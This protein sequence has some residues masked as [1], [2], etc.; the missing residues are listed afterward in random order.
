[1]TTAFEYLNRDERRIKMPVISAAIMLG[2]SIVIFS[3]LASMSYSAKKLEADYS[4]AAERMATKAQTFIDRARSMLPP[5][6]LITD[7]EQKTMQHNLAISGTYSAWT[8]F[9]NTLESALPENSV[10]TAIEN[11]LS[12]K[13]SFTAED[14]FFR[15]RIAVSDADQ[16]NAL[17]MKLSGIKSIE[18]LS[19][20]P[21]GD[22]KYQGRSG[23]SIEV[24]F[25]FNDAS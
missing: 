8:R 7:L 13:S 15:V 24:E 14:R 6:S 2:S 9:F 19:F 20:T 17:Y 16:A 11:T 21:K 12:S 4:Q 10:I 23:I 5:D 18:A 1:M 25:K 22:I 3:L